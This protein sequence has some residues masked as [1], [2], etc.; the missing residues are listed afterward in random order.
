MHEDYRVIRIS[1]NLEL[2][3]HAEPGKGAS[4]GFYIANRGI[5]YI[6]AAQCS[7][8][9]TPAALWSPLV[10]S[11]SG[12]RPLVARH[13]HERGEGSPSDQLRRAQTNRTKYIPLR[14]RAVCVQSNTLLRNSHAR[15]GPRAS[16]ASFA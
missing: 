8:G 6:Q 1:P 7:L 16:R 13:P 2:L 9:C 10:F 3:E 15:T 12:L 4:A 5:R 14:E 11:G